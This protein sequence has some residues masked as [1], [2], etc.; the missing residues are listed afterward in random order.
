VQL[1]FFGECS[2]HDFPLFVVENFLIRPSIGPVFR[3]RC[4]AEGAVEGDTYLR[5]DFAQLRKQ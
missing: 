5:E 4:D 3:F 1:D 2:L